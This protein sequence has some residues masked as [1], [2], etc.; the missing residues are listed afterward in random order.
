MT[1]IEIEY[2][3]HAIGLDYKKPRWR[4]GSRYYYPYRNYFGAG[5]KDATWEGLV[6]RGLADT[7]NDKCYFVTIKGLS[8]L[9][10]ELDMHIYSEACLGVGHARYPIFKKL[11]DIAVSVGPYS[12][13]P[14]SSKR[15]ARELRIPLKTVRET[16]KFLSEQGLVTKAHEG[17]CDEEGNPHCHHGFCI[18]KEATKHPYYKEANDREMKSIERFMNGG[19]A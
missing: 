8:E 14:V 9:S 18:T 4:N 19:N 11:V 17:Y 13:Y 10:C 1:K 2:M 5:G 15:L 3:S 6:E 7:D 12:D 16:L